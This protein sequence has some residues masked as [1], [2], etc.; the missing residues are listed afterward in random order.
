[1]AKYIRT[2]RALGVCLGTAV[3]V[4][5]ALGVGYAGWNDTLIVNAT[6]STGDTCL[7]GVPKGI[8]CR[9]FWK[10][11][12]VEGWNE[13]Y[14]NDGKEGCSGETMGIFGINRVYQCR[15]QT[16]CGGPQECFL[17]SAD[18]ETAFVIKNTG[19]L[20]I[21]I[22][23]G[24]TTIKHSCKR[25][26]DNNWEK[27]VGVRELYTKEGTQTKSLKGQTLA[28][29]EELLVYYAFD[30]KAEGK[31]TNQ[32]AY[33]EVDVELEYS[34]KGEWEETLHASYGRNLNYDEVVTY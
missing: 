22:T 32:N 27:E 18:F 10:C 7:E 25:Y 26:Q 15:P 24:T 8:G 34:F 4:S 20:P 9:G 2:R 31:Q 11:K 23:G 28:P 6:V 29:D 5:T 33:V 12:G 3:L 14:D 17:A 13:R 19:T 30:L 1:M 21:K 16:R